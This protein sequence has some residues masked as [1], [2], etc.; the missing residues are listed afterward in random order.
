[1][2]VV[3][4]ILEANFDPAET[5][6]TGTY[7]LV[8][9]ADRVEVL[10][11][12]TGGVRKYLI[13]P[14]GSTR[15]LFDQGAADRGAPSVANR[16]ALQALGD[17]S[18]SVKVITVLGYYAAGD[19]AVH[20][21]EVR[22]GDADSNGLAADG[23]IVIEN[24]AGDTTFVLITKRYD[25]SMFGALPSRTAAENQVAI[26]AGLDFVG[27]NIGPGTEG[28]TLYV[29]GP[30]YTYQ[31]EIRQDVILSGSAS[32]KGWARREG[33]GG[34]DGYNF[35]DALLLPDNCPPQSILNIRSRQP[36]IQ[37]LILDARC[38]FQ[39]ERGHFCITGF[40][41][42]E[43]TGGALG[44]FGDGTLI[45]GC[46]IV[47][48]TGPSIYLDQV[49]PVNIIGN[50]ISG[51]MF[52]KSCADHTIASNE[53]GPNVDIGNGGKGR[54]II[55]TIAMQDNVAGLTHDNIFFNFEGGNTVSVNPSFTVDTSA[56]TIT[57]T[58]DTDDFY[59]RQPVFF[60]G[61]TPSAEILPE[62]W[63]F[64]RKISGNTYAI[65]TLPSG[66]PP[67][68]I[69]LTNASGATM[70]TSR[71]TVGTFEGN[72][73]NDAPLSANRIGIQNNRFAG[74]PLSAL[75]I[76]R[77]GGLRFSN[78]TL[79]RGNA[80]NLPDIPMFD[81]QH[82]QD[83]VFTSNNFGEEGRPA[84]ATTYAVAHAIK[85]DAQCQRN[86]FVG[87]Q[88]EFQQD[89]GSHI[90]QVPIIGPAAADGY[91]NRNRFRDIYKS[92]MIDYPE[93]FKEPGNFIFMA[94]VDDQ[95][96]PNRA[97]HNLVLTP[98]E[99]APN[100][101]GWIEGAAP[102]L[103]LTGG[104]IYRVSGQ[105]TMRG[106]GTGALINR[107]GSILMIILLGDAKQVRHIHRWDY[108]TGQD[109]NADFIMPF[110][111][112]IYV[113]SDG[114]FVRLQLFMEVFAADDSAQTTETKNTQENTSVLWS[115]LN[116]EKLNDGI[117]PG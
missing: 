61:T 97:S 39:Q 1:M 47:G 4:D 104:S 29:H 57:I 10:N 87:N 52:L 43:T 58:S 14:D 70:H 45:K 46:K 69:N 32:Y 102:P 28:G 8:K 68:D 19:G 112:N 62:R 41:R 81:M 13:Q 63:Y 5:F 72:W 17:L 109:S 34:F 105:I 93:F 6:P 48:G 38:W 85:F 111:S 53:V 71:D 56:N 78:N 88:Y 89:I 91:V 103:D 90:Q 106:T 15:A 40:G 66:A 12:V 35:G 64:L 33:I 49:G 54:S 110:D 36:T 51:C 76:S 80:R 42:D 9:A 23:N 108:T 67:N 2:G 117:V 94:Q 114:G 21:F 95:A 30:H 26:Q 79:W 37:N 75:R 116:V 113:P 86:E 65:A 16:A 22:A 98:L 83:S 50:A 101:F 100:P 82:V 92:G 3:H 7:P 99:N 11:P 77:M 73:I 115:Y 20:Q 18:D 60:G 27:S 24:T 84:S 44:G 59:D 107:K 31:L 74:A 96:I 25:I 55:D